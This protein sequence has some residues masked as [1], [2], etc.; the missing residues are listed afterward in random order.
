MGM[1]IFFSVLLL[2]LVITYV[3]G[4]IGNVF[5][6]II[7]FFIT[8]W[9]LFAGVLLVFINLIL[10][11]SPAN[12]SSNAETYG[13]KFTVIIMLFLFG[14]W[15]INHYCLPY[16]FHPVSIIGNLGILLFA[17]FLVSI[18]SPP[19]LFTPLHRLSCII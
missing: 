15:I 12:I 13:K 14:G 9:S 16:R 11:L 1:K 5:T 4:A 17:I 2:L 8:F 3:V 19:S 6:F 18:I 7:F 10:R